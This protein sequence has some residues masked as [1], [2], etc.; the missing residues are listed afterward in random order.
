MTLNVV[1]FFEC[2]INTNHNR[3]IQLGAKIIC[4]SNVIVCEKKVLRVNV[5]CVFFVVFFSFKVAL[6]YI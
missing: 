2:K 1:P 3:L 6:L 4:F 5:L